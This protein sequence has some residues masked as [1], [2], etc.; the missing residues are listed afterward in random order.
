MGRWSARALTLTTPAQ[1]EADP[2]RSRR[3]HGPRPVGLP[4][5]SI[6]HGVDA[7][8]WPAA[9]PFVP[10]IVPSWRRRRPTRRGRVLILSLSRQSAANAAGR[11]PRAEV[12]RIARLPEGRISGQVLS[13]VQA[14]S[15]ARVAPRRSSL[16]RLRGGPV[17]SYPAA[18]AP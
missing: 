6:Q 16:R 2:S 9:R 14:S 17:L 13:A 1:R 5:C 12:G 15:A 18:P 3:S 11:R 4:K 10:T 8:S 7:R